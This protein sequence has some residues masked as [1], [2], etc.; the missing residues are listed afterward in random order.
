M[1]IFAEHNRKMQ[2]TVPAD[3]LLVFEVKQGWDPL[4][5]F[6]GVPVPPD[7]PFPHDNDAG[8]FQ[9]RM[10]ER[11]AR[12]A[13]RRGE[14]H[15]RRG[16]YGDARLGGAPEGRKRENAMTG[17]PMGIPSPTLQVIGAGLGRTGTLSLHEALERLGFAP[18]EHMTKSFAQPER[19]VHWLEAVRCKHAGEAIDWRPLFTG[20]RATVDWPGAYFWRELTAAHPDAKVILTVRDPD[21]WYDSARTTIYAATGARTATRWG[22]VFSGLLEWL[23]P[24]A[25]RA[26]RTVRATVW[27]G[28]FVGQFSDRERAL[29]IFAAHNHAVEETIPAERLLVFDVKQGWQP[30]CDFLGVLVP[31][32]EPFPHVNDA[33]DFAKQHRAQNSQ[34]ARALAPVAG[35]VIAGGVLAL[36]FGRR[37]GETGGRRDRTRSVRTGR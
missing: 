11:L 6:L 36:A 7:E 9:N 37:W 10:Q 3:R 20:Y 33:A 21:R 13:A 8:S 5:A 16:E 18:C 12:G 29:H 28:T 31:E 25:G 23:D 17:T 2:E 27:D 15:R 14:Y 19:F 30:L 1:R 26:F 35:F 34:F 32:G 22:R 4:C 24:S